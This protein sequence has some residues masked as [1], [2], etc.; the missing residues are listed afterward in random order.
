V[1]QAVQAHQIS[2]RRACRVLALGRSSCRYRSHRPDQNKLIERLEELA[3]QRPR[4]GYRR[5]WGLL[6]QEGWFI[7]PKRVYRLYSQR[8]LAMRRK[9]KKR[10]VSSCTPTLSSL[11]TINQRWSMDFMSDALADGRKVRTLNIL[12]EYS[13][14]CL[15]IEVDTSLGAQRVVRALEELRHSR[16][17][18]QAVKM[19][20][21]PEFISKTLAAWA[22]QREVR[23]EFIE[24]GKPSQNG[25]LESFNGKFRDECLNVHWFIS[26]KDAR[27]TIE[28]WRQDYNQVRP[29]SALDYLSPEAFVHH[30]LGVLGSFP[31][32]VY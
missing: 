25:H 28:Q 27:W 26:L 19:D 9:A 20:N 12:D 8:G 10:R 7:N 17:L 1:Q 14:E 32:L 30:R 2:E 18:P 11:T 3:A 22:A 24:P 6:R 31:E 16:G 4:Y 21:G 5:L 15:A 29:H 13:R 23:L